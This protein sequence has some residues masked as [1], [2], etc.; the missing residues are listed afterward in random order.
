MAKENGIEN[1]L[2][3]FYFEI[4]LKCPFNIS[5]S[6]FEWEVPVE[7]QNSEFLFLFLDA[8]IVTEIGII[9]GTR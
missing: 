1:A 2:N 5:E 9:F 4:C 6:E 8:K 7:Y 3:L